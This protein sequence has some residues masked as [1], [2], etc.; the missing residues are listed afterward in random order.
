MPAITL[1]IEE[2][3]WDK[4]KKNLAKSLLVSIKE[5]SGN[6]NIYLV[7]DANAETFYVETL[8]G[9]DSWIAI[10]EIR[11]IKFLDDVASFREMQKLANISYKAAA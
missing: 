4:I 11:L 8:K 7:L 3:T 10:N 9:E 6:E 1:F 5:K 2:I